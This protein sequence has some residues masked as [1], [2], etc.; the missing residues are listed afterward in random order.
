M[1]QI[2]V[3]RATGWKKQLFGLLTAHKPYPLLIPTRFG[4]HT[5]GMRYPIDAVVLDRTQRIVILKRHL[6]PNHIFLWNPKF[7]FVLELPDGMIKQRN[8][9]SNDRLRFCYIDAV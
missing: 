7:P 3:Y 2:T 6:L 8:L 4:I 1:K 9:S 5:F